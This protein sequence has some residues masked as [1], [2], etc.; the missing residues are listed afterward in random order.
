MWFVILQIKSFARCSFLLFLGLCSSILRLV[1]WRS[2]FLV[3]L[4]I[5]HIDIGFGIFKLAKNHPFVM[6]I[7]LFFTSSSS[8]T[9]INLYQSRIENLTIVLYLKLNPKDDISSL[10]TWLPVDDLCYC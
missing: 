7:M 6:C 10:I 1:F 3:L 2:I 9:N 8:R 4:F 5:A